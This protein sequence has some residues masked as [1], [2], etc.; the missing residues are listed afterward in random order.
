VLAAAKR[1]QPYIA[2]EVLATSYQL[3]EET[4]E[5]DRTIV[6]GHALALWMTHS[7]PGPLATP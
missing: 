6:N 3:G 5:A 7:P 1:F 2:E 4:G